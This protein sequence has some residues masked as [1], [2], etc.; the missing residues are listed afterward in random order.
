MISVMQMTVSRSGSPVMLAPGAI[1][2]IDT[3][4]A[5]CSELVVELSADD[6]GPRVR[7]A[8]ERSLLI[9]AAGAVPG[10]P[11]G[12]S[13]RVRVRVKPGEASEGKGNGARDIVV[14]RVGVGSDGVAG[15]GEGVE[16]EGVD[17]EGMTVT[18]LVR[19]TTSSPAAFLSKEAG[20]S[21][22][23]ARC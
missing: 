9:D 20:E 4:T 6:V 21:G 10:R 8:G 12:K 1:G 13:E 2:T 18:T 16:A 19:V 17:T 11:V 23:F 3:G 15:T 5:G 22:T 7:I 14:V